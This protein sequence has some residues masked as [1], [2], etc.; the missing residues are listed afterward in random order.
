MDGTTNVLTLWQLMREVQLAVETHVAGARWVRAEVSEITRHRSGHVYLTLVEREGAT[1]KAQCRANLWKSRVPEI[2]QSFEQEIG[3]PLTQ[4]M[5]VL[6][7][8][9]VTMSPQYG[10]ALRLDA[11]DSTFGL[12][13]SERRRR[14]TIERLQREGLY[15]RNR[16]LQ[17]PLVLQRLAVLSSRQAA[18]Y[19]DFVKQLTHNRYGIQF[20]LTLFPIA[21]QGADV[22]PTVR[23][24]LQAVEP[25]ARDFDAV[26]IL[27]GGGARIDLSYFDEYA[28]AEAIANCALPVLTGIG[29]ERDVSVADEVAWRSLKTPTALAEYILGCAEQIWQQ[30]D[31]LDIRLRDGT[32][33]TLRQCA[34]RLDRVA[35]RLG[36]RVQQ[37]LNTEHRALSRSMTSIAVATGQRLT[38]ERAQT[39][40][41]LQRLAQ[42]ARSLCKNELQRI[43]GMEQMVRIADPVHTL[44]RGFSI[45]RVNGAAI[46]SVD[47]L[48][49]GQSVHTELFNGIIISTVQE[50]EHGAD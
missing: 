27:R 18:G 7:L 14:Q 3:S 8:V 42:T 28:V 41:A 9:T 38:H 43:D 46:S 5:E 17:A 32:Q 23:A 40:Y 45:T 33:T 2:L 11:L 44:R 22:A 13:E 16:R 39:R 19:E 4:G 34:H 47:G 15:D 36:A 50:V 24:A 30:V 12:G 35:G 21:L 49:F 25:R 26:V 10:L 20:Q 6:A 48:Q 29:H 31:D 1:V 37:R